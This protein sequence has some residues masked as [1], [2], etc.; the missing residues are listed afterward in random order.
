[1]II[2]QRKIG[3][4]LLYWRAL[5]RRMEL[6]KESRKT[7]EIHE[8]GYQGE[9]TYDNVYDEHLNH[10][11]VFRGIYLKVGN[12]VLQCD[13]LMVSDHG[14]IVHEIKNYSGNYNYENEKWFVRNFQISEDPLSQLKRT[15]NK[16][17]KIGYKQNMNFTI[18]GKVVFPNIDFALTST[19]EIVWSNII[20][21]NQLKRHLIGFK[22]YPVTQ[23]AV[24]VAEIIQSH[25]IDDPFFNAVADFDQLKKGVYCRACGSFDVRKSKFHFKCNTCNHKDT[26]H[27][28]ILSAISDLNILFNK[29]NITR[30]QVW[31]LLDKQI[32]RSSISRVLKTYCVIQSK[33]A[34]AAYTFKYYDFE[35]AYK[36]ELR[37][38]RYKD[39]PLEV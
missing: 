13:A 39:T 20:M 34:W 10:L 19:D 12:S 35:D 5:S 21:R 16:L 29:Q 36:S 6:D 22:D 38:W 28:V 4:E 9:L 15:T 7:L 14:L 11:Y 1:M 32:A 33:G 17:L 2:H 23:N 30:N 3:K 24:Q 31:L 18:E 37:N 25:I 27:T 8:R 26:I